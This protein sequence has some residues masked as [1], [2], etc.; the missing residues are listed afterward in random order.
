MIG[1][2]SALKS[3]ILQKCPD[4]H[5]GDLF[6]HSAF[7]RKFG[8]M[9]KNCPVCGYDFIQEPS[10]YFGAMYVSYAIQVAVFVFVYFL[11]RYTVDPDTWT[12]VICMIIGSILI[13]PLNFRWSRAA[14]LTMFARPR[15]KI[16]E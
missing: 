8:D 11:L 7:S 10:F 13:L 4:C 5:K 15:K 1:K 3:I 9:H 2:D 12:Y 16:V 6:R 14:Y